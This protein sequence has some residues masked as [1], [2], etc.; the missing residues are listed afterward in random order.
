MI[1]KQ[2]CAESR[3][4]DNFVNDGLRVM[5]KKTY[6]H[7]LLVVNHYFPATHIVSAHK[8][9]QH[10]YSS[11]FKSVASSFPSVPITF[12]LDYVP[13]AL[14]PALD[15]KEE[16]HDNCLSESDDNADD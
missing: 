7:L 5:Q 10:I 15:G 6:A 2:R 9:L 13:R 3:T 4:T 8:L 14:P 11:K 1:I 12:T 16:E